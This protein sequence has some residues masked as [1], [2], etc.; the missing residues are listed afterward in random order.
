MSQYFEDF[1]VGDV[2]VTRG[3]TVTEADIVQYA[4]LCWDTQA[5][6]TNAEFAQLSP[7]GERIAQQQ[8]GLLIAQGLIA[9]LRLLE[10]TLVSVLRLG[11]NFFNPMR[12]GDTL[13]VKQIV[14]EKKDVLYEDG[15]IVTFQVETM[16]QKNELVN[17]CQRTVL[18]ARR[19][20]AGKDR[21]RRHYVFKG[22]SDLEKQTGQSLLTDRVGGAV[23]SSQASGTARAVTSQHVECARPAGDQTRGK[24]YEEF[25]VGE[26]LVTQARTVAEA[27]VLNYTMLSWDTDP[28]HTDA[29]Y[30]RAT[31]YGGV[32]AP[33][34]LP[35][36]FANGLGA[37]LGFLAGTNRGA[38]GDWWEFVQPARIGDTLRFRQVIAAKYDAKDP[39]AGIVTFGMEMIN[40][41]N[42]IVSRGERSALVARVPRMPGESRPWNFVFGTAQELAKE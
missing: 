15:G 19:S 33:L 36:I 20:P 9:S 5:E 12:I 24:Y 4:G 25:Q 23:T 29:E 10:D 1:K 6:H 21:L 42:E 39:D 41:R 26:E 7:F 30:A 28:L 13:R 31:P 37:T 18:V 16:N 2:F 32:I 11:W 3:R 8:L 17:R 14:I 34:L 38:L 22:L 40:Q 27:D 35:I